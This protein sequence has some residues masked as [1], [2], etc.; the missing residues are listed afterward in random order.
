MNDQ[1]ENN[2]LRIVQGARSDEGGHDHHDHD[3]HDDHDEVTIEQEHRLDLAAVRQKLHGKSGKHY[4]R[5]LEEL[6]DDPHFAELM[7]REFPRHASEWDDAVDRRDFLKLMGAS[8]ALAGLAGCGRPDIGHI[9]PYVKQPDGL[10]LGKPNFYATAMPFGAST[11]GVLVESHEGRPTKIEGNPDHP[12]SLGAT[13]ALAQAAILNLY[14][15]DRSQTVQQAGEIRS[16][17]SFLDAAQDLTTNVKAT[18]G[19]GFRILS[20]AV[21]SPSLTAQIR[22]LLTQYPQAKWYQWEPAE[23]DGARD[24]AKLAF[25]RNVNTVYEVSKANVIVSLD[26]DFLAS[27]PG[28]IAY[29]RQFARRRQLDNPSDTMNRLYVVEPTP[30]V[31]GSSSDHRL[32]MRASDIE[33]FARALAGKLGIGSGASLSGEAAQWLE[34]VAKDLQKERGTSLVV[35]GEYQPASVHA[36]AHAMNAAL[37]NVGKTLYY[38]EPLAN[39]EGNLDSL[40][41]LCDEMYHGKVDLLLI[42]GGNPVYDAPHDFDFTNKLKRVSTSIHLS[43]YLDETSAYCQWHVAESHFL[44]TWSDARGHDGTASIIQPLIAPLYYTHSA[45]EVVAAFSDKP[46]MPAYEA[47]REYWTEASTHLPL[48][49][50]A[51]W[52]KWLNDGVI[53]GTKFNPVNVESK[54]NA[55]TLPAFQPAPADQ[56]EYIFRPDPNVHDGRFANNGWL[57][58]LPKPITKL[59]WDNAALVGP[60][61]AEKQRFEQKVQ[62]RGGEHGQVRAPLVDIELNGSKVTAAVWTLPGQ[63]ENTVVLPLGYGRTRSGYTGTNKGFNAYVVRTSNALWTATGGKITPTGGS[64]PLACTQYHFNMEGRQLLTTGTLAEYHQNPGFAHEVHELPAKDDSLYKAFAYP[65][66]AWGMAIDLTK[67]NGCNACVVACVSE[68]NIPVV[69]KDQVMRGREMHWIRIDRYYTHTESATSGKSTGDPSEYNPTLDNPETFFQPVPCQQCENAPCEQVC[70]VGATAHSAEGLND[71]VYNRCIGTRYCSNNC[72]YKVRRFNFLRFQDWETP[73]YKLMR[74]PEVTVRSRGVMEKCTY[75]VQRINNVRIDAEKQNRPIRDGEIVTACQ[76]ACPT[77]AIVF[78][79]A[80]DPNSRVAKLK[81][82]QRNYSM[83]GELNSRPRTTY[84]A[85]VRNPNPDLEKA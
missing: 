65:G 5:T 62:Y 63:D 13:S 29:A 6:A 59:T 73:Q 45:H 24:G 51:G 31:T 71:M 35:A 17:S 55:A 67:C 60:K 14:D 41:A 57:Q 9:V 30:S 85:A 10:V 52:R 56:V 27:G 58:E 79:N 43:P 32:P 83:L 77:E 68:N 36:L 20:G 39:D 53:A 46:G 48:S 12:S 54:F 84:L 61:M 28:H 81:A 18:S 37:G 26:S 72:P 69:G 70:P 8:L 15:P 49:I 42:L 64:Y 38:T 3:A 44:E 19:A 74:N 82:Q 4:W 75:C 11:V 23:G 78:G 33:L 22:K 76:S 25:G 47:V 16:W 21:T 2:L 80:N 66:Y 50:D 7:H 40:R 34:A 1:P